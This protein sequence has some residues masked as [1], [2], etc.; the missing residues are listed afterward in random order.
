MPSQSA[1]ETAESSTIAVSTEL[2]QE[3]SVVVPSGEQKQNEENSPKEEM[4]KKGKTKITHKDVLEQQCK[5][6]IA[7]QENLS[8][9]KKKLELKVFLLEQRVSSIPAQL[10]IN[11]NPIPHPS[12]LFKDMK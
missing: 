1:T 5:A 8:L 9:K 12:V 11:V 6:L 4:K 3:I 10:S 2:F 7:K